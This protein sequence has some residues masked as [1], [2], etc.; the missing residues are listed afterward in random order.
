MED[1]IPEPRPTPETRFRRYRRIFFQEELA[2]SLTHGLG[3]VACLIGA[4]ALVAV[5]AAR[6]DA[7]QILGASVFAAT[8][9]AL[10]ATSTLY[11]AL[12][13]S[14]T[15][16]LLRLLDHV[17]IY[18]LIAGS[19]TPFTLGVLRG[20]WGWSLLGV[21]WTCAALGI[22]F[23]VAFGVR[24]PKLSTLGY[25]VMGWVAIVAI[26]PLMLRM[27]G[28]GL[29][30]IFAGGFFYMLGVLFY[31]GSGRIRFSHAAWHLCVIGGSACHYFAALWYG[32]VPR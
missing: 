19:Y 11:H 32:G 30:L 16:R 23:K 10:Y 4:P 5:A 1:V 9:L 28:A 21:I 8:L 15:K 24:Y 20:A 3:L 18:L 27:P 2:N 25:V 14:R 12:P 13:P 26:R 31:A 7:W 17:A 6:G 29:A 22:L